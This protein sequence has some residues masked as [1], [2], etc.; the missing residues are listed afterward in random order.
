MESSSCNNVS[1][2]SL[3][4][5]LH[6]LEKRYE[7]LLYQYVALTNHDTISTGHQDLTPD[8]DSCL[9]AFD[10]SESKSV[11]VEDLKDF[12][13]RRGRLKTVESSREE[14]KINHE[15]NQQTDEQYESSTQAEEDIKVI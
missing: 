13:Q 14:E 2:S 9:K 8:V 10:I 6:R 1:G 12:I 5:R 4:K 3:V 15:S 11:R 7:S